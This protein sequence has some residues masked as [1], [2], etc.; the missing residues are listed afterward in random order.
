M[1]EQ[2]RRMETTLVPPL[3]VQDLRS[4]SIYLLHAACGT[5]AQQLR[6]DSFARPLLIRSV[7]SGTYGRK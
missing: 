5:E 2:T 1:S 3:I 6:S 4:T 7:R